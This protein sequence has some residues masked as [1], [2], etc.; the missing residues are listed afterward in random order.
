MQ[1]NEITGILPSVN[2]HDG[3]GLIRETF[4]N[5]AYVVAYLVWLGAIWFH[6]TH[7]F[8]SALHTIG[9]NNKVWLNR[10][11]GIAKIY[12]TLLVLGFAAV[13]VFFY[14]KSLCCCQVVS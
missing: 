4:G 9:W 7:G 2:P 12:A 5:P 10:L 14:L 13:I 1:F 6:L 3:A 8:W 11:Q